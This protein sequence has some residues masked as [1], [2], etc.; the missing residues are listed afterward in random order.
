LICQLTRYGG[1]NATAG[2]RHQRNSLG[3]IA[4]N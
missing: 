3:R 2:T 4:H 1:S